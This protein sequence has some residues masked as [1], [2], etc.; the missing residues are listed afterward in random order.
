MHKVARREKFKRHPLIENVPA[1]PERCEG[2]K[3]IL[4]SIQT[5]GIREPLKCVVK[6]N[7]LLVLDGIHRL[8]IAESLKVPELPYIEVAEDDAITVVCS[9]LVRAEWS[10]S[11][12]AYRLWPM[13]A[14][15]ACKNGGN[16]RKAEGNHFP[17]LS[18][19]EIA[20]KMGV[21]EKLVDQAKCVHA[22][23]AKNPGLR[24]EQE[25]EILTGLLSLHRAGPFTQKSSEPPPAPIR[26]I[27][28]SLARLPKSFQTW[29]EIGE[30]DRERAKNQLASALHQLP[31]DV[32]E[33]AIEAL[34]VALGR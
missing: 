27:E 19:S 8:F 20:K 14:A 21:S 9:S 32:Q 34:E 16:N 17:L 24:Q 23:F 29:G 26:A 33:T 4:A 22:F 12:L 18:A 30:E 2:Y 28:T 13:F 11:A 5:E 7:N 6:G 10:K 15:C 31:R 3:A 25:G 1:L